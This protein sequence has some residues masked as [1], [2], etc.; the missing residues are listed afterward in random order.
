MGVLLYPS[1]RIEEKIKSKYEQELSTVRTTYEK[2]TA[3]L[4]EKLEKTTSNQKS[5]VKDYESKIS[6]LNTKIVELNSKVKTSYFK[7]VRP[8]G[9]VEVRRFKESEI[10]E[11]TK[12]ISEIQKDFKQKLEE[13]EKLWE[14]VHRERVI[15]VRQE[16]EKKEAEYQ[17][18]IAQLE[19]SKTEEVNAKSVGAEIGKMSNGNYYGHVTAD[20]FGP[21]FIGAQGELGSQ[22]SMGLGIGLRF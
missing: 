15:L 22:S 6:L 13:T 2:E 17:K 4:T 5:L 14:S 19:S 1:K 7:I 10:N 8:D 9:T 12:I 18:K 3:F 20:F 11:S 16:F 21:F